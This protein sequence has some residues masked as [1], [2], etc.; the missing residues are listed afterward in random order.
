[1]ILINRRLHS[2]PIGRFLVTKCHAETAAFQ[3]SQTTSGMMNTSGKKTAI[4]QVHQRAGFAP[5]S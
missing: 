1:M 5:R 3:T 4:S 2:P